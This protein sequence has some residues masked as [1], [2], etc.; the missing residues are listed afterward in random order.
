MLLLRKWFAKYP[1]FL[2]SQLNNSYIT[3]T[4]PHAQNLFITWPVS[5]TS[6]VRGLNMALERSLPINFLY[7]VVFKASTIDNQ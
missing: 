6:A 7:H 4:G 1:F 3:Y 2:K 5:Q